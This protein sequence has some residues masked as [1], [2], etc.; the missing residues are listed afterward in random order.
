MTFVA[1]E[2]AALPPNEWERLYKVHQDCFN[3]AERI[4]VS[5]NS[6]PA[7]REAA[8]EGRLVGIQRSSLGPGGG[9]E[10]AMVCFAANWHIAGR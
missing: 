6:L 2:P 5:I 10:A 4:S 9:S 1:V 7:R 3:A 8:N